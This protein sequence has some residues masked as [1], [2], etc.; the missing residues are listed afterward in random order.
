MYGYNLQSK[1]TQPFI[2]HMIA[3]KM[4]WKMRYKSKYFSDCHLI[5]KDSLYL[6]RLFSGKMTM[7]Y[8]V[9]KNMSVATVY[10]KILTPE[11]RRTVIDIPEEFRGRS[12]EIIVLPVVENH[13]SKQTPDASKD[14]LLRFTKAQIDEWVK[15]PELQALS[16]VLKN[17]GLPDDIDMKKIR[18]MRTAEKYGA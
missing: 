3:T 8:R 12:V 16:G 7:F 15:S 5:N 17:A 2:L 13:E 10:R 4:L 14:A 18:A 1:M 9:K 11:T 6:M